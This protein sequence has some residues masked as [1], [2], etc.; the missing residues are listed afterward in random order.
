MSA[1]DLI[2]FPR[3]EHPAGGGP[4]AEHAEVIARDHFAVD[5]LGRVVD[6]DR[7]LEE[8][9]ADRLGQRLRLLLNVLVERIGVHPR[10]HVAPHVAAL[11]V[12]HDQLLGVRDGKLA[13]QDLVD[14]REDRR[15][16]ADAQGQRQ[17]GDRGEEGAAAKAAHGQAE[18]GQRAHWCFDGFRLA[19]VGRLIHLPAQP[20]QANGWSIAGLGSVNQRGPSGVTCRQSSRRIPNS[21]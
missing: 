1:V 16:R 12:E 20:L 15:I 18:I 10:P 8:P 6:R 4:D 14:Q 11:L 9:P 5:P 7:R 2:V 17:D 19:K 21:P 3:I 13:Q